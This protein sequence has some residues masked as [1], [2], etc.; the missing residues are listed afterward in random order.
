[1]SDQEGSTKAVSMHEHLASSQPG[2]PLP[3]LI[4]MRISN[5]PNHTKDPR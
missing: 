3:T 2:L 4:L 5:F 1:M